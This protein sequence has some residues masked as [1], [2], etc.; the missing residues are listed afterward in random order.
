M[1]KVTIDPL[2]LGFGSTSKLNHIFEDI[3]AGFENTLSRDGTG[4]NEMEANL[5]MNGHRIL[6]LPAP[7][8]DFEPLRKI[9]VIGGLE[10]TIGSDWDDITNKP[11]TFAPSAHTHST[12]DITGLGELIEDTIGSKVVAGTNVTVSYND[13]TGQTTINSTASGGA[14][15]WS[16]LTGK[17]STFEPTVESVQDIVATTLVAGTNVTLT[18][19]D[20]GNTLTVAST[21]SG[22]TPDWSVITG[23]PSTFEPTIESVQDIVGAQLVAGSGVSVTYNDA[24]GTTTIANTAAAPDWSTLTGKPSTFEPVVESVQDI[25]GAQLLGGTGITVTYNDAG[26]TS[27]IS[28]TGA[29][30]DLSNTAFQAASTAQ[31][32]SLP[33]TYNREITV[34]KF[35]PSSLHAAIF[36]RTSTTNV[37]TYIQAA[38]DELESRGGGRLLF[39]EGRYCISTNLRIPSKVHLQ[40]KGAGS[41]IIKANVSGWTNHASITGAFA[42]SNL[43][44]MNKNWTASSL[45]DTD[46]SIDGMTLDSTGNGGAAHN[47]LMRYVDRVNTTHC[48]FI[49]GGNG[50]AFLACRDT[51]VAHCHAQDV[52]N[53]F[54]DHWDGAGYAKVIGCTGRNSPAQGIL[55]TATSTDYVTRTSTNVIAIGNHLY[56]VKDS[57]SSNACALLVNS[58]TSASRTYSAHFA[59]NFVENCDIGIGFIGGGGNHTSTGDHI[60]DCSKVGVLVGDDG[61]GQAPKDVA[62]RSLMVTDCYATGGNPAV[63]SVG[64][65][66]QRVHLRDISFGGTA[67]PAVHVWFGSSTSGCTVDQI[68]GIAAS[69]TS[70]NNQAGSANTVLSYGGSSLLVTGNDGSAYTD[71]F[72]P[73]MT[74]RARVRDAGSLSF[75]G[76]IQSST[77]INATTDMSLGSSGL[78]VFGSGSGYWLQ[79]LGTHVYWREPV[80]PTL[81]QLD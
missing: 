22:G 72:A 38:L 33:T 51:L 28:N 50:T 71:L 60:K 68:S 39:E 76:S 44:M 20:A 46:I 49:G 3:E 2:T 43:L 4:P 55:F 74:Y 21:G 54:Y 29:L 52:G 9:D 63:I 23:K 36:A 77:T 48:K 75:N 7:N 10:V 66:S 62:I 64:S 24:A 69:T 34:T 13:T 14:S 78:I 45:T 6:N 56:N 41:T 30:V 79:R 73:G 16:T 15:D 8:T 37:A 27:T 47:F 19:N 12:A 32:L 57:V 1:T 65:T 42:G 11:S 31:S 67:V 53:C 18:Y 17:P 80:G 59:D 40:G 61:T 5:D 25:V 26:G 35:I 70:I 58:L 81:I